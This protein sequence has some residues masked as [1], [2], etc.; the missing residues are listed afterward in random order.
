[1]AGKAG[2]VEAGGGDLAEAGVGLKQGV[3]LRQGG[4]GG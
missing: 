2:V 1:M 4:R 3:G